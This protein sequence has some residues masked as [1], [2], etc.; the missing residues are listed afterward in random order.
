MGHLAAPGGILSHHHL[1]NAPGIQRVDAD[2]A[3]EQR[4]HRVIL[5][6]KELPGPK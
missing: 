2:I 5:H 1:R 3:A 4:M 6:S